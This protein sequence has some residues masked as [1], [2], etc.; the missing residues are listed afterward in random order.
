MFPFAASFV[1]AHAVAHRSQRQRP[2]PFIRARDPTAHRAHTTPQTCEQVSTPPADRRKQPPVAHNRRSTHIRRPNTPTPT[3]H[4]QTR[5]NQPNPHTKPTHQTT[6]VRFFSRVG[7]WIV[8]VLHGREP[9]QTGTVR[10]QPTQ[11]GC[12]QA[13]GFDRGPAARRPP[14]RKRSVVP[15]VWWRIWGWLGVRHAD[16]CG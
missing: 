1:V 10:H 8:M 2:H 14:P 12:G 15:G 13:G 11:T 3:P 5:H 9:S 16:G 6:V 7:L 4:T